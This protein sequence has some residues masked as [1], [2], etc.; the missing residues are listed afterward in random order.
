MKS[1]TIQ[2]SS[3]IYEK[4]G[5]RFIQSL[6]DKDYAVDC[7]SRNSLYTIKAVMKM[8][9][10]ETLKVLSPK[11]DTEIGSLTEGHTDSRTRARTRE[12]REHTYVVEYVFNGDLDQNLYLFTS[13][14]ADESGADPKIIAK[15]LG[16]PLNMD[17]GETLRIHGPIAVKEL[18]EECSFEDCHCSSVEGG[19]LC[20]FHEATEPPESDTVVKGLIVRGDNEDYLTDDFTPLKVQVFLNESKQIAPCSMGSGVC[21]TG[22]EVKHHAEALVESC[23]DE[24]FRIVDA[25]YTPARL[26]FKKEDMK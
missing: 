17:D 10:D 26:E 21:H 22:L 13:P 18:F 7:T 19:D 3:K 23:P 8:D 2:M 16:I 1:H 5:V 14:R 24:T 4:E 20:E 25:V 9:D 6:I 15:E 11:V 12:S